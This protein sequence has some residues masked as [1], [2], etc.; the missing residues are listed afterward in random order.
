MKRCG[1]SAPATSG[2]RRRLGKPHP[3]QGRAERGERPAPH[4]PGRPH[5]WMATGHG[6]AG[7][8]RI[9][10]TGRLTIA[11]ARPASA[12]S[13]SPSDPRWA[14][15]RSPSARMQIDSVGAEPDPHRPRRQ[16]LERRRLVVL[17][18]LGRTGALSLRRSGPDL[19]P[20]LN[21]V[22]RA[23]IS[24]QPASIRPPTAPADR[25]AHA[26][27]SSSSSNRPDRGHRRHRRRRRGPG[28]HLRRPH[29]PCRSRLHAGPR[30]APRAG[31]SGTRVPRRPGAGPATRREPN[32]PR[33]RWQLHPHSNS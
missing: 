21:R 5:R 23:P 24:H 26:D 14:R 3:E 9:P 30:T 16:Q 19:Q 10:L 1:K 22:P 27:T 25:A 33:C 4:A 18:G 2:D 29:R 32:S 28:R 15:A 12:A 13:S 7:R 31:R 8:H 6:S 11:V 20:T 17:E